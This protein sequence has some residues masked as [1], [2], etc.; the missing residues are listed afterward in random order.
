VLEKTNNQLTNFC[1]R[2][3]IKKGNK[4][5]ENTCLLYVI[6]WNLEKIAD[7]YK[8]ICMEIMRKNTK[9]DK[10]VLEM[11]KKTNEILRGYYQTFYK[12]DLKNLN[13]LSEESIRLSD[14]IKKA[15][16]K[17]NQNHLLLNYLLSMLNKIGDFSASI[18]G[19]NQD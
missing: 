12:F 3:L 7:D 17:S 1:E 13:R 11:H 18:V 19:L 6:I 15:L 10:K 16:R 2:I 8:Y 5:S 4:I 9:I 14:E